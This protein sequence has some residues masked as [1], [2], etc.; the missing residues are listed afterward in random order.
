LLQALRSVASLLVGA[1]ILILGNALIGIVVPIRLNLEGVATELSGLVM[2][3]YY[4]G[5]VAGSF[6]G[7]G[8]IARVGHI[9]A[10]AAF[11]GLLAAATL[12]FPLWFSPAPWAVLRAI[13]GFCMAALFATI[14][15][16]LNLRS[17]NAARGQILSLYMVTAYFGSGAGQ[18]LVNAWG[19][20]G[21]ELFCLA[22]LLVSISLVPV[23]L[24]R[25]S[26]PDMGS[27][28]PLGLRKLTSASPLGVAGCF[29]A[30]VMSGAF[31][32]L[33]AIFGQDAGLS[34][35][36]VSLFMGAMVFG[37]LVLQW[38]IGRLSDRFDRRTVLLLMLLAS[39]VVCIAEYGWV[40]TRGDF[41]PM[42]VLVA[43]FGGAA[44]TVY[45]IAVAHTFDYV[46]RD[47]MV[48][49]SSGLLLA[50]AA[51][52]TIGPLLASPVMRFAGDNALFLFLA[53]VA[54]ALAAFTR[55]RM[56]RRT[57]LPASEQALFVPV[58]AT[59][60]VSGEL[61]PRAEHAAPP[62]PKDEL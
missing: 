25:V 34:V 40:S 53:A 54:L 37:G 57:A 50:W 61:D 13:D 6:W 48:A 23:T 39:A 15:S 14:E 62:A 26:G 41:V 18:L 16:W 35:F 22:A 9:R 45:P 28:R 29:G 42:L 44:S 33:G 56:S 17:S 1:G 60:G 19:V 47:R 46:D 7:K 32:G 30:G 11:A 4:A 24:T 12:I 5:F 20:K 52:A 8:I 55:Y 27:V 38:P 36:E 58:P 3:A 49:A 2:S 10:F 59:A 51:G 43:L 21:L 31:Y